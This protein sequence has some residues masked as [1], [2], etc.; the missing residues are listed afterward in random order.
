MASLRKRGKVWYYRWVD[1]DGVKREAAGCSDRR[2]TEEMARTAEAEAAKIRSG[3]IDPRDLAYAAHERRTL[4]DHLADFRKSLEDKGSSTKHASVTANRAGRVLTLAKA[5]RIADLSPSKTLDALATLRRPVGSGGEGLSIETVNHHVRAVKSFSRWLWKDK[6]AREHALAH[7]ATSNP[8]SDRR[9]KRRVL[10]PDEAGRLI[11]ATSASRDLM[12]MSGPD[13]AMAYLIALGT[14]FRSEEI[15]SLTPEAFD[16]AAQPPTATV[17]SAY[18]KNGKEAVQPLPPA[19]ADRL[20][21]W[22]PTREAGRPVLPLPD[23]TAEMLRVDLE[24]AG[25]AY[26]TPAGVVDFHALRGSYIS[27]VVSSGASVKTAQT[28]ARHSTPSL[29]IGIYAKASTDDIAGAMDRLPDLV[30]PKTAHTG[31]QP[32]NEGFA[33][34]LPTT[35]DGQSH[36]Q[37]AR[38]GIGTGDVGSE[39]AASL[40]HKA[41]Q[42]GTLDGYSRS[43]SPS[44]PQYRRRD[45]NS[46]GGNPPEDFKSSA[47]AIPPRR[48]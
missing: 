3:T 4:A 31:V 19:L 14:G 8:E 35:R 39:L 40:G 15:R 45:S 23:R 25:I 36:P 2:A 37:S 5:R 12:G 33:H 26:E 43:K 46:H 20:R 7:L 10:T 41:L 22:L 38:D 44:V 42:I 34:Y 48:P 18:T 1:G 30:L 6:R 32:I 16:L 21:P 17:S 11:L 28:L 27:H 24:A 47:S 9:R 13:R 29:T